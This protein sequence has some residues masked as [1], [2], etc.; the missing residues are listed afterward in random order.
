[1]KLPIAIMNYKMLKIKQLLFLFLSLCLVFSTSIQAQDNAELEDRL[2]SHIEVLS[3]DA[4]EGREAGTPGEKKSAEYISLQFEK[5]NLQAIAKLGFLQ[6]FTF[7]Y[8]RYFSESNKLLVGSMNLK[9]KEDYFPLSYSAN[10]SIDHETVFVGFGIH[11]PDLKH[12]DYANSIDLKDKLFVMEVGSPDGVHPHSKFIEHYDLRKKIETAISFGA[13]GV[14]FVNSDENTESPKADLSKNVSQ[15]SIPVVFVQGLAANFLKEKSSVK[16][17]G[18]TE[19]KKD[20]RSA[21][22]VLGYYNNSKDKTVVIGAHH[23]HL[24]Y[25]R[26]GSLHAGAPEIHNGA[27]DNASGIAM[28]IELARMIQVEKLDDYN[29]LFVGF[30][31][32]EKGL[33]GSKHFVDAPDFPVESINYMI[34]MDMVG[35]L[36]VADPALVINGVGTS[37][38]FSDLLDEKKPDSFKLKTTESGVGPSDHTSF[39]L[40]DIPVLHFFTGTH[41]DY[42]KPSDDAHLINYDGMVDLYHYLADIIQTLDDQEAVGF[43]KTDDAKNEN[44]PRFTVTLGVIPDYTFEEEGMRIDGIRDGKPASISGLEA[45]DVV[46]QLGDIKVYDMMSYM[47]ALSKFKKGEKTMVKVKRG[48]DLIESPVQF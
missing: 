9:I 17:L 6:S 27:D 43:N 40:K 1:M 26:E 34:N 22:N 38:V 33:L 45:G 10:S 5:L 35:R 16:V 18:V 13:K 7:T 37:P 46:V 23:D 21:Y 24:G 41:E 8:D 31:A 42:H 36:K 44:A 39:Y 15:S 32:E 20:V 30:S 2:K 28:M 11:A 29:Y 14:V 3:S 47:K 4:Y 19:I 12:N 48:E 25:G